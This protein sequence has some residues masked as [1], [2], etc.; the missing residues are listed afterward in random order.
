MVVKRSSKNQIVIPKSVL[1]KA[2]LGAGDV[3]FNVTYENG[4]I[5]LIPM[6]FEE[7]IPS[8]ALSRF[9]KKILKKEAGDQVHHSMDEV[10]KGLHRKQRG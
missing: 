3:F 9:E 1:E 10:I 8:E 2:G 4:K 6:Q 7:K 5:V